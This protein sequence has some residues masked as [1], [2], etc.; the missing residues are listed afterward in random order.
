MTWFDPPDCATDG[1]Y[2]EARMA[3][4]HAGYAYCSLHGDFYS[5]FAVCPTCQAIRDDELHA[6]TAEDFGG[7]VNCCCEGFLP[8][9]NEM[10]VCRRTA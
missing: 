8:C 2:I 5:G 9:E 6:P 7:C 3:E 1:R 4:A 10:C